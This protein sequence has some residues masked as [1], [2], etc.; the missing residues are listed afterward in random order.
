MKRIISLFMSVVMAF[1]M[2]VTGFAAESNSYNV[3][4]DDVAVRVAEE[5][6]D[7]TRYVYTFDKAKQEL[8]TQTFDAEGEVLSV[9]TICLADLFATLPSEEFDTSF[10]ASGHYQNTISNYEYEQIESRIYQLRTPSQHTYRKLPYDRTAIDKYV[11]A[12][13]HLNSTEFKVIA[14]SSIA[15]VAT[16]V[17]CLTGGLTVS[18]AATTATVAVSDVVALDN[19]IK[20]CQRVWQLY[21]Q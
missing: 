5:Y 12:V 13:D 1:T 20:D 4:Q 10:R 18:Q 11:Q 3:I 8:T 17:S 9:E 15:A 19:A 6:I 16:I 14:D 7:G 21:V 2:S